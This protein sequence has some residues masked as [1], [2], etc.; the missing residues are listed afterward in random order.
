MDIKLIDAIQIEN[1]NRPDLTLGALKIWV[2]GRTHPNAKYDFDL[3]WLNVVVS[4]QSNYS[5]IFISG[6]LITL[7]ELE[8]FYLKCSK[9]Y[10]DLAGVAELNCLEPN[11]KIRIDMQNLGKLDLHVSLSA[12]HLYENH[13]YTAELDQTYLLIFMEDVENLISRFS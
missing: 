8:N 6:S 11:L 7:F 1:L 9:I 10:A 4:Y 2:T 12:D 3:S 13:T 5:K